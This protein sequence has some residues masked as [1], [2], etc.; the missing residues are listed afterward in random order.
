MRVVAKLSIIAVVLAVGI[1]HLKASVKLQNRFAERTRILQDYQ[2][3]ESNLG[4]LVPMEVVLRFGK[5]N[6][7][8][9]WEQMELVDSVESAII[10][11]TAVNATYSAATFR[12]PVSRGRGLRGQMQKKLVKTFQLP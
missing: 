12:P 7:L 4:P 9:P 5:D 6:E 10:Q 3:L 1:V 8:T 2:W 11:T